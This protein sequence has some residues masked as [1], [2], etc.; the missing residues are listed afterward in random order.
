M[1]FEDISRQVKLKCRVCGNDQFSSDYPEDSLV[2]APGET[3][4]KCAYCGA[5]TTKDELIA[6]NSRGIN[7]AVDDI[8]AD[9]ENELQKELDKALRKVFG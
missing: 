8:V 1:T 3:K 4:L 5:E 9:V 7:A 2:D 6:D